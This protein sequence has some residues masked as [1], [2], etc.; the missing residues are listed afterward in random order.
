MHGVRALRAEDRA[1]LR[2]RALGARESARLLELRA[3]QHGRGPPVGGGEE[4]REASLELRDEGLGSA[5]AREPVELAE[6]PVVALP[7]LARLGGRARARAPHLRLEAVGEAGH[8]EEPRRAQV[9]EQVIGRAVRA[10]RADQRQQAAAEAGVAEGQPAVDRIG[11]AVGAEDL[12]EQ[13]RVAPRV[14]EDDRHVAGRYAV[15]EQL[16]H[17]LRG[18]L[19]LGALAA[20]GVEGDGGAGAD[21][22]CR[23]GLEEVPLQVVERRPRLVRVV[24]VERRQLELL[25]AQ[26]E[27]LLV[28]AGHRLEREPPSLIGK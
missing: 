24:V 28:Q 23:L 13:R 12:L 21:P 19:H 6:R 17:P 18:E 8:A 11:D 22:P 20:G 7:A 2:Q 10:G 9:R 5:S 27:Q 26:G 15:A 4:G 16:E 14:A 25:G 3:A 1:Q